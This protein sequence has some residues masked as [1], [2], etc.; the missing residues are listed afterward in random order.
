MFVNIKSH[1]KLLDVLMYN[2]FD[3]QEPHNFHKYVS[4][5]TSENHIH[6]HLYNKYT[7]GSINVREFF[8]PS[9]SVLYVAV[10][11]YMNSP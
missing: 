9:F 10:T 5:K 1:V 3:F 6:N 7:Y 8:S 11:Q 2:P 4:K